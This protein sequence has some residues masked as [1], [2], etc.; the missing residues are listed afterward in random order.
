MKELVNSSL[1][2]DLKY[3]VRKV[4]NNLKEQ[5]VMEYNEY[6]RKNREYYEKVI[7]DCMFIVIKSSVFSFNFYI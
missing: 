1:L 6:N 3:L 7:K 4:V 2:D 5:S